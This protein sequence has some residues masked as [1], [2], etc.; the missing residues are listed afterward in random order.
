[1]TVVAG[2]RLACRVIDRFAFNRK[3]PGH[4][5][6][7]QYRAAIICAM[8]GGASR[9]VRVLMCTDP[10]AA[11]CVHAMRSAA[12][13]CRHGLMAG[14]AF[15]DGAGMPLRVHAQNIVIHMRTGILGMRRA[16]ASLALQIA[17]P[18]AEAIQIESGR[19]N[20]GSRCK[21]QI[22]WHFQ[23]TRRI[24]RSRI[25]Y[26]VVMTGLASRFLQPAGT[27]RIAYRTHL[28]VTAL[29][30]HQHIAARIHRLAHRAAQA[31]GHRT[32][33]T[34]ITGGAVTAGI[35]RLTGGRVKDCRVFTVQCT[36][37][38]T[39]ALEDGR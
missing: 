23:I 36:G 37:E 3:T 15:A 13:R 28:A 8:T 24:Q 20:I 31:L 12:S 38:R 25:T 27:S 17:V 2:N 10:G 19:R 33:M 26:P 30:T 29:A 16:V 35:E 9:F 39:D 14:A 21:T 1:M 18:L 32:R 11:C 22:S 5:H 6:L 4:F 34:Q 7:T